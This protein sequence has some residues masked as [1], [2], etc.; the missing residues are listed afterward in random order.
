MAPSTPSGSRSCNASKYG[1]QIIL[2]TV[3]PARV[4]FHVHTAHLEPTAFFEVEGQPPTPADRGS[5]SRDTPV[6]RDRDETV[7]PP[8]IKT[9]PGSEGFSDSTSD[10]AT[11]MEQLSSPPIYHLDGHFYDPAAF[12]MV[13][14]WLYN[15]SPKKPNTPTQRRNL[16]RAYVL[17]GIYRIT[18]LQDALLDCLRRY[19]QEFSVILEDL[20]W[21]VN[22]LGDGPE[23]H[24]LPMVRY[25]CDQIAWEAKSQGYDAFAKQNLLLE[26]FLA[27]KSRPIRKVLFKAIVNLAH[28]QDVPLIDPAT[29]PNRWR[30]GDQGPLEQEQPD[31]IAIDD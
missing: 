17:A 25:L 13:V 24:E 3:G 29:G 9:E 27:E 26:S 23:C 16:L 22:R 5:Q 1:R 10:Q 7:S 6:S 12:E 11:L 28:G 20:N 15:Q 2:I 19:H 21:L 8:P 31:I 14:N 30:A 18:K 4:R